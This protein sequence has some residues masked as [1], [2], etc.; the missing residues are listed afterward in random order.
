MKDI[1]YKKVLPF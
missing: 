1:S